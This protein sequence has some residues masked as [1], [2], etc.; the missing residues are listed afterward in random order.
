M[1]EQY[2]KTFFRMQV[3]IGLVVLCVLVAA[4]YR[5]QPAA[6]FFL[7]MQLFSVYGAMWATRLK[8]RLTTTPTHEVTTHD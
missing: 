5:W 6:G 1:W 3:L 4:D 8:S 2:R 7:A